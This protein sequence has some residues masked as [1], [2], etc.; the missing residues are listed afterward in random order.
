V[1]VAADDQG[2][3]PN[4]MLIG[5]ALWFPAVKVFF[6]SFRYSGSEITGFIDI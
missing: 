2:K 1:A 6:T 5:P 3:L 4:G